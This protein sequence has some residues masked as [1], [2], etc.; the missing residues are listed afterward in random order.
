MKTLT[1]ILLLSVTLVLSRTMADTADEKL[2]Y[3]VRFELGSSVFAPGDNITIKEVRGTNRKIVV[4]GTY[5]VAGTYTLNSKDHA[6]LSFFSTSVGYS[7][8]TPVDPKQTVRIQRGAGSFYLVIT[9]AEDGYLHVSF[10]DGEDFGGVYFGQ[11]NRVFHGQMRLH[12]PND[13]IAD[14]SSSEP[15]SASGPNQTLFNYLG[16]PVMPPANMDQHYTVT[17]LTAAVLQAAENAGI[18]VKSVAVDDSEF[19]F[20]VGVICE[21]S[22]AVKLKSALKAMPGYQYGGGVGNDANDDGS[23]TCNAFCIVPYSAFPQGTADQIYHRLMLR[24]AVFHDQIVNH[25]QMLVPTGAQP[26]LPTMTIYLGG[27]TL[28]PELALTEQEQITGMMFRTN[29][30]ETDSM[31]FVLS[32]PQHASFWMKNCQESLSAAYITPDG[33]IQ[34]IHHFEPNDTTPVVSLN[35]NIQFVLETKEGWFDR[36]NVGIGTKITTAKGTLSETF[37]PKS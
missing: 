15:L 19:P 4:G 3:P 32:T 2:P 9:M 18:T 1:S 29:I 5:S 37:L 17:G 33:V 11:G 26:K 7:G 8:P 27:Q 10:Y 28:D 36:H 31:L 30:Q 22:D 13:S 35:D 34:E 20:L 25:K 6:G 14:N 23:D 21:G 24:E 16:N 12:S